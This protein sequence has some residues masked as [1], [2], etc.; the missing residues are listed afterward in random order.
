MNY[1]A[2]CICF[3]EGESRPGFPPLPVALKNAASQR[4]L[5]RTG[6]VNVPA[7]LNEGEA[8]LRASIGFRGDSQRDMLIFTFC[9]FQ[10]ELA[11]ESSA[12]TAAA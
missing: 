9:L 2:L 10:N 6:G 8:E 12:E 5:G 11:V 1:N 7:D 3:Q 4:G